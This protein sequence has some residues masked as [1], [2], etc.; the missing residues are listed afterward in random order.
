MQDRP[1]TME[2]QA[3]RFATFFPGCG[4]FCL[5]E[6]QKNG[7]QQF[8]MLKTRQE[9]RGNA[10]KYLHKCPGCHRKATRRCHRL[11]LCEECWRSARRKAFKKGSQVIYEEVLLISFPGGGDICALVPR[12]IR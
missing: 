3:A 4:A 2:W 8:V 12:K 1:G 10:M 9:R 11:F 5:V 6:Y 7:L